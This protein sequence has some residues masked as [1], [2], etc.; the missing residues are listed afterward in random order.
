MSNAR[1]QIKHIARLQYPFFI[2]GEVFQYLQINILDQ[3]GL[4]NVVQLKLPFSLACC[5]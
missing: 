3:A 1:W 2:C 4:I 5:L